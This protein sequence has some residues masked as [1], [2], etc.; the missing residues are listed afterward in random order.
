MSNGLL[1]KLTANRSESF[2]KMAE[3]VEP[4]S[5]GKALRFEGCAYTRLEIAKKGLFLEMPAAQEWRLSW[6]SYFRGCICG[7]ET[8]TRIPSEG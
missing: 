8:C 3:F 7:C 4:N 2:M 6:K 1:I 5:G